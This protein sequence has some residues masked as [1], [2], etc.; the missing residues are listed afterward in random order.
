MKAKILSFSIFSFLMLVAF[1][2]THS[3]KVFNQYSFSKKVSNQFSNSLLQDQ[4]QNISILKNHVLSNDDDN[5]ILS[6]ENDDDDFVFAGKYIFPTCYLTCVLGKAFI[7]CST[8]SKIK[9]PMCNHF[10]ESSSPKY[11]LQGVFRI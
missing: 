3:G 5:D 4:K 10:S 8:P 11:L 2:S 6:F 1:L 9:L 7:L